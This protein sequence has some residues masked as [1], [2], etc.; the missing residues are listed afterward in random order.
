MYNEELLIDY[1]KVHSSFTNVDLVEENTIDM[2][3]IPS[4]SLP[5]ISIGHVGV[6][7]PNKI[8]APANGYDEIDNPQQLITQVLL[9]C[10]RSNAASTFLALQ[11]SIKGFTPFVNDG[12]YGNLTFL[13]AAVI[14][15]T[16]KR[17]RW[18][19][20]YG[21]QFPRIS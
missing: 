13:E 2:N 4:S 11:N 14:A 10:E 7:I 5:I 8:N 6:I 21:L 16:G 3:S 17:I 1:I 20:H 9:L 19:L 12:A 18:S 15:K